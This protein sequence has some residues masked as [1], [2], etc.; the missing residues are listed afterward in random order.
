MPMRG[1]NTTACSGTFT[2]RCITDR[3]N[4]V[5]LPT[6]T[7]SRARASSIVLFPSTGS[8]RNGRFAMAHA[9]TSGALP[10]GGL[11]DSLGPFVVTRCATKT[12]GQARIR[13][14]GG[15]TANGTGTRRVK[16]RSSTCCVGGSNGCPFTVVLPTAANARNPVQFAPTGRA[17]HV[18][19]RCP[20]FTG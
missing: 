3:Q 10:G 5:R 18:S 6:K 2:I 12:S 7:I 9:F 8:I 19:L 20:S 15:G 16:T 14:P 13:L 11:R 1:D 17:M 4:D